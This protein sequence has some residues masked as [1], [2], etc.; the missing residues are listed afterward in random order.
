[1]SDLFD[2]ETVAVATRTE[3]KPAA[4]GQARQGI[5]LSHSS[6]LKNKA[7]YTLAQQASQ[8]FENRLLNV[9]K[10][11]LSLSVTVKRM[12]C[13]EDLFTFRAGIKQAITELKYD[14]AK[15]EYPPSVADKTCFLFAAMLD[16]QIVHSTW[17][18]AAG[19]ENQ[20]LVSE[21]FGIKNGGEQFYIV[22]ERALLQP[23]LLVDML[24]LIYILLKVGFKGRYRVEG[25]EQFTTI[26]KRLEEAVFAKQRMYKQSD[27]IA[28][29][30]VEIEQPLKQQKPR[31]P[32][33]TG[34]FVLLFALLT[35]GTWGGLQYW[36]Q[37]SAPIKAAPFVNLTDFTDSIYRVESSQD[38]EY[39]YTSMPAD[40][41]AS[42]AAT[43]ASKP[44]VVM[45]TNNQ[46]QPASGQVWFVQLATF[47]TRQNVEKFQ[48]RYSQAIPNTSVDEW[49]GKYRLLSIGSN[50]DAAI[51]TLA[52]ANQ[53]GIKD[54][55]IFSEKR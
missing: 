55:F 54:A 36:Y 43:P 51:Q 44:S 2:E 17:G 42:F 28:Q 18:E 30:L 39:V 38:N 53:Q 5:P 9:S 27:R 26:L 47:N 13:P 32:L 6:L 4:D 23:V 34:R 3:G 41:N 37:N 12:Q 22:A 10:R 40:I 15:L 35:L 11:L 49:Q 31:R 19:W 25:R 33:K 7:R 50:R 1:M 14:I 45:P 16:E 48:A 24:E 52:T 46:N 21:L 29:V 20:T 8:P